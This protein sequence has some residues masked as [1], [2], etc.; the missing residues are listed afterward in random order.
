MKSSLENIKTRISNSGNLE[1]LN[2]D[3]LIELIDELYVELDQLARTDRER[4]DS[5]DG[6]ATATTNEVTRDGDTS[7]TLDFALK[8]LSSSV[9]ELEVSHPR[10]ASVVNRICMML[11]DIGI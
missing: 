5:V 8:G 11:S 6:F 1:K 10:L 9:E 4:A 3:E 7:K 2:K